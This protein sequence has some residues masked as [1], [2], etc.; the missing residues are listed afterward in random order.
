MRVVALDF[1]TANEKRSS[2]CSIG[3]AWIEGGQIVRVEEHL[4]RPKEMRFSPMNI[5]IHGIHP[6]DVA[7]APEFPEVWNNLMPQLEG[8]MV[9]AHN[10]AFDMSVVRATL[11]QYGLPWPTLSYL[12]TVKVAQAVWPQLTQHKLNVVAGH[13]G[14]ALDHHRA[15]SDAAGCAKVALTAAVV[16]GVGGVSALPAALGIT[17][18]RLFQGGYEACSS[19]SFR[20]ATVARLVVKPERGRSPFTDKQVALTGTLRTMTRNEARVRV[21]AAGGIWRLAVTRDTDYL[22]IGDAPGEVKLE[23]ARARMERY[24]RPTLIGEDAF[25][26]M[27]GLVR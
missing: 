1:E 8:A 13:L 25:V 7:G 20:P 12:C 17:L 27:L 6:E 4:I 11:D 15:G 18:G 14:I 23:T 22:V 19:T 5:A 16:A 26:K 9:L 21:Q 3:L 10:A 2:P 24:G